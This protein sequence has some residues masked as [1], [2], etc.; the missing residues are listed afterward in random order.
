MEIESVKLLQTR[1]DRI[2]KRY[3][4]LE[5]KPRSVDLDFDSSSDFPLTPLGEGGMPHSRSTITMVQDSPAT[6]SANKAERLLGLGFGMETKEEEGRIGKATNWFMKRVGGKKGS[7]KDG[8]SPRSPSPSP[9]LDSPGGRSGSPFTAGGVFSSPKLAPDAS[10][11]IG[12]TSSPLLRPPPMTPKLPQK[13]ALASPVEPSV[14]VIS[15]IPSPLPTK[16]KSTRKP[17]PPTIMTTPHSPETPIRALRSPRTPGATAG[18]AG[19][20][21]AAAGVAFEFE[22]PTASPRSDSFDRSPVPSSP[23]RRSQ[24]PSP[25]GPTSPH[26]SRSFSKR[27]SLL[28]PS[29]ASALD[30]LLVGGPAPGQG[31]GDSPSPSGRTSVQT[32]KEEEEVGYDV[33]KHAYAIRMLAELEDAQ[34]EVSLYLNPR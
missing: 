18:P 23:R 28:P 16:G 32:V 6:G 22:L 4:E 14:S 15:G 10:P 21:A 13:N 30:S 11:K 7:R 20:G 33:K 17:P 19:G 24:P 12:S 9:S 31:P 27:S 26:M 5:P 1:L 25:R 29:T 3:D 8:S 2:K 34:K